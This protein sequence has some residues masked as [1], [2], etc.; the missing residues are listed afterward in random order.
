MSTQ[1]SPGNVVEKFFAS[2]GEFFSDLFSPLPETDEPKRAKSIERKTF[3]LPNY[4][5]YPPRQ[6]FTQEERRETTVVETKE[7][8]EP[9]IDQTP[10][11]ND[12]IVVLFIVLGIIFVLLGLSVIVFVLR[13][14]KNASSSRNGSSTS[15]TSSSTHTT[16]NTHVLLSQSSSVATAY[17]SSPLTSASREAIS[18]HEIICEGNTKNKFKIT[19]EHRKY[20]ITDQSTKKSVE[21]EFADWIQ[22]E[23]DVCSF[24]ECSI[25]KISLEGILETFKR[26]CSVN[27]EEEYEWHDEQYDFIVKFES[28][29]WVINFKINPKTTESKKKIRSVKI[30]DNYWWTLLSLRPDILK[31]NFGQNNHGLTSEYNIQLLD[32]NNMFTNKNF[33]LIFFYYVGGGK[34]CFE[35]KKEN[36]TWLIRDSK[37][38]FEIKG[39]KNDEVKD[40]FVTLRPFN[41]QDNKKNKR[42]ISWEGANLLVYNKY[43]FLF[44][45]GRTTCL[46]CLRLVAR[47]IRNLKLSKKSEQNP[48][49]NIY[50]NLPVKSIK[51]GTPCCITFS[52]RDGKNV[53]I[54]FNLE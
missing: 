30:R 12:E 17:A 54:E 21:I 10:S 19:Y 11:S 6:T 48:N 45:G 3:E 24:V 31:L 27:Y 36:N 51:C 1:K 22:N 52:K 20:T 26:I 7:I 37:K 35:L 4:S 50:E 9:T 8:T 40:F 53:E 38:S 41:S 29:S 5:Q 49:K 32:I 44:D 46:K 18:E 28:P 39:F 16:T 13:K 2:I 23:N 34:M 42:I 47:E 14:R 25:C 33:F 43:I 15:S